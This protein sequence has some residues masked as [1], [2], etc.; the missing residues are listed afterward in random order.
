M[1]LLR[2]IRFVNKFKR[3]F[4]NTDPGVD[5]FVIT[6]DDEEDLTV[7]CKALLLSDDGN[8][9]LTTLSGSVL[10]MPLVKGWNP[11]GATR[12]HAESTDDITIIGVI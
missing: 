10:I 8:V 6:P 12:V 3:H 1:T 4:L 5:A 2:M 9:Q 11:I 7:P